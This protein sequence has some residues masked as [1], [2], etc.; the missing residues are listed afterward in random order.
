MLKITKTSLVFTL[1][2]FLLLSSIAAATDIPDGPNLVS[3]VSVAMDAPMFNVQLD[4]GPVETVNNGTI[5]VE[6][7][8]QL[9][10]VVVTLEVETDLPYSI[11]P[12]SMTFSNLTSESKTFSVVVLVPPETNATQYSIR[13]GGT[14]QETPGGSIQELTPATY[15]VNVLENTTADDDDD[16]DDDVSGGGGSNSGGINPIVVIL[17]FMA[18]V[19]VAALVVFFL[20]KNGKL[21]IPKK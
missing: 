9:R 19:A 15:S 18:V 11:S 2:T 3:S 5:S 20:W 8:A 14:Y 1:I 12:Q 17:I 4:E 13:V 16:D 10:D 6:K 7:T 21:P